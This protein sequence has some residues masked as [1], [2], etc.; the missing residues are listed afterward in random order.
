ML[1]RKT[2]VYLGIDGNDF[3]LNGKIQDLNAADIYGPLCTPVFGPGVVYDC[4]N[5]RFMEQ[6]RFMKAGFSTAA[7]ESHVRLIE[8][9]VLDY[10]KSTP[11]LKGT[12]GTLDVPPAMAQIT[13]F[14]AGRTLQGAEVRRKL[15]HEVADLYH[16]L[17]MGFQ[18]INFIL[19]WAPLPRNRR[20]DAAQTKMRDMYLGI[21]RERR[22]REAE[23]R[24]EDEEPDMLWTLMRAVYKDGVSIADEEIAHLMI[25]LLLAGQHTAASSSSWILLRLASRPDITEELYQEQVRNLGGAKGKLAPLEY[26]DLE[27]LP[28]L[29]AVIKETLRLHSSIHSIMRKVT[30]PMAVPGSDFV[31]PPGRTV[32]ASPSVVQQDPQY[33]SNP[34]E[35]DPHRWDETEVDRE[36]DDEDMVDYGFGAINKGTRSPYLP[37]GA[38]RHRCIGEAFAYANLC[39]IIATLVRHFRFYTL[40]GSHTVPPTDYSS[41]FSIP[42]RPSVVRWERRETA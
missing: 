25:A 36:K 10:I 26:A 42:S 31:I 6:K 29:K 2:T 9:E 18:P 1:G 23:N 15:T 35:W 22:Q 12:S 41:M 19:P 14:T 33:F 13:I 28:L 32:I 20:R 38:G 27:K 17:D 8:K 21:I 3:I 16:D 34:V 5:T 39:A 37:F 30:R 40:D 24:V 11:S 4:P 7:L